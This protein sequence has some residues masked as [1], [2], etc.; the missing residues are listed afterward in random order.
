MVI[1]EAAAA[2]LPFA[3]S[4]V[5][6]IPD[7]IKDGETG[8][9]F[10]PGNRRSIT[11]A[12]GSMLADEPSAAA[13]ADNARTFCRRRFSIEVVARQHLEIYLEV[14]QPGPDPAAP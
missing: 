3:A 9:L 7:L 6:G 10:D 13:M 1:L 4:I 11:E 2:G 14:A 5:G 8:R 12:V